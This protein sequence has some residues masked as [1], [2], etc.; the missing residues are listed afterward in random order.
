MKLHFLFLIGF[1]VVA[2]IAMIFGLLN[3]ALF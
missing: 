3:P 1:L 2:R